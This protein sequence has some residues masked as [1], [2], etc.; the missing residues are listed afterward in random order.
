MGV[1]ASGFSIDT[2]FAR[3][4]AADNF[5]CDMDKLPVLEVVQPATDASGSAVSDTDSTEAPATSVSV[6]AIGQSHA[7]ARYLA[8]QHG[9]M[10]CNELEAAHVDAVY[11]CVRDIKGKWLCLKQIEDRRARI[12]AKNRWFATELPEMCTQLEQ[13]LPPAQSTTH[14]IAPAS[15]CVGSRPSLADIAVYHL[16]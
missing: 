15:R 10:G 7:I 5:R 9:L 13:S 16:L 8:R 12:V 2:T 14:D 4:K 6:R 11:E 1:A 3:D